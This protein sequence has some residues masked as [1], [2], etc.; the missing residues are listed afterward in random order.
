LFTAT[1]LRGEEKITR[2]VVVGAV[3]IVAGIGMITGR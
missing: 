3:L 2:I 1:F